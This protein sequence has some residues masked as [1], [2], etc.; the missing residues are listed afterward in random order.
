MVYNKSRTTLIILDN[1]ITAMTGCQQHA[2]TGKALD[3]SDAPQVD[4]EALARTLGVEDVAVVDAY[5]IV[6]VEAQLKHSLAYPGP[7][8]LITRRPCMLIPHER[9]PRV[10]VHEED[11]QA[12]GACLRLGC[13][14]ISKRMVE[15]EG[16]SRAIPVIDPLQC[17]GCGVCATIC[18]FDALRECPQ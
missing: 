5:D 17:T 1:R 8:V 15:R 12:C 4:L 11:C 6:A 14:A 2:G 9:H 16:K 3:G 7:S 18:P 10:D 13:P